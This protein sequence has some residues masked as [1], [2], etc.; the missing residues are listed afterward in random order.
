MELSRPA[1]SQIIPNSRPRT[2][3]DV[4]AAPVRELERTIAG[5]QA[6]LTDEDRKKLQQLKT[7]SH[8]SQ[9]IITFTAELDP[10]DKNRRGKSNINVVA[11]LRTCRHSTSL[12]LST[13]HETSA[14]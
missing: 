13:A 2:G 14:T 7:T 1:A 8:D 10:L 5:F 12:R 6:I 9:S 11:F 4:S 3:Q